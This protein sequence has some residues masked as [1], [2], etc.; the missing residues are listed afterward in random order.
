[1]KWGLSDLRLAALAQTTVLILELSMI[2]AIFLPKTRI[3]LGLAAIGF[4]CVAELT[5]GIQFRST[6]VI[7]ALFFIPWDKMLQRKQEI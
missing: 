2:L 7:V 3:P 5:L 4:H 1:M 6:S